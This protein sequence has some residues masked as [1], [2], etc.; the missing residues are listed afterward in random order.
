MSL[1]YLKVK[2]KKKKKGLL[3]EREWLFFPPTG[4]EKWFHETL[5]TEN[6]ENS[7]CCLLKTLLRNWSVSLE[8]LIW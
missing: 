8:T 5:F 6:Y 3:Q 7:G 1:G 4:K 2:L